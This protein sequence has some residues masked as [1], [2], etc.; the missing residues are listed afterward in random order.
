M[1]T[2]MSAFLPVRIRLDGR[3]VLVSS[4]C[5]AEKALGGHW[6]NKGRHAFKEATRLLAAAREGGCKPEV[7]FRAFKRAAREQRMLQSGRRSSALEIYDDLVRSL[8]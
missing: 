3:L 1:P 6:E 2:L 7:A 4:I 5:D 8:F